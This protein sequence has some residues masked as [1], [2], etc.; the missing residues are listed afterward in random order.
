MKRLFL[1]AIVAVLVLTGCSQPQEPVS[2]TTANNT[3][4]ELDDASIL[5]ER[6]AG[7]S[8]VDND[9]FITN[10]DYD[11]NI[12]SLL[13]I[14]ETTY[15][16]IDNVKNGDYINSE[17]NGYVYK[18]DRDELNNR[19]ELGLGNFTQR[20]D[21]DVIGNLLVIDKDAE[22]FSIELKDY[23][24]SPYILIAGGSLN[25]TIKQGDYYYMLVMQ[26][27]NTVDAYTPL[28]LY[29]Y[30][31]SAKKIDEI[32]KVGDI[33]G[34]GFPAP[35]ITLFKDDK[36]V[37]VR[38]FK[39]IYKVADSIDPIG[40]SFQDK[41]AVVSN[42]EFYNNNYYAVVIEDMIYKIVTWDKEWNRLETTEINNRENNDY[43]DYADIYQIRIEGKQVKMLGTILADGGASGQ[44]YRF[45]TYDINS[46]AVKHT[47]TIS[48]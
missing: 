25:A 24:N 10:W 46:K 16:E 40:V 26:H 6:V 14:H 37:Y 41:T 11:N 47:Q 23:N 48:Q 1:G 30:S 29:R 5:F 32:G 33:P 27:R 35:I 39:D 9:F 42:I 2:E 4:S 18:F 12:S 8:Y 20:I 19:L 31:I 7:S 13:G 43:A 28:V 21:A 38:L 3:G 34:R 36:D 44:E 17:S 22:S 45:Y 15:D